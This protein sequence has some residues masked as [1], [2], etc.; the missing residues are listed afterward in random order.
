MAAI[1]LASVALALA[2]CSAAYAIQTRR[3]LTHLRR[4]CFVTNERGH[5]VRYFHASPEV[6]AKAEQ[7]KGDA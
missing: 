5:R 4:N 6:R 2:G 1:I 7:S 3:T